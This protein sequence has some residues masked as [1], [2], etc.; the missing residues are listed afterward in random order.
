MQGLLTRLLLAAGLMG[1][2]LMPMLAEEEQIDVLTV[3]Q[4]VSIALANNRNLKIV[5][6]NLDVHNEKLAA[7]K[8]KR[9]PSF[10]TYVFGSQLLTPNRTARRLSRSVAQKLVNSGSRPGAQN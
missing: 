8:T 4:A 5:S 1:S 7:D 2:L 9:L 3:D 6:L 10:S